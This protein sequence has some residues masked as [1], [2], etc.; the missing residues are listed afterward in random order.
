M[1]E[2]ELL[3]TLDSGRL[4]K[5]QIDRLVGE[6]EKQPE[7]AKVLFEAIFVEDREVSLNF[8]SIYCRQKPILF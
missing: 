7:L 8:R 5:P 2:K 6:L 1:T 3:I 4:S